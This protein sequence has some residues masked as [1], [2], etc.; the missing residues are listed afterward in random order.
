MEISL[1][2]RVIKNK[3][4]NGVSYLN[5]TDVD[6]GLIDISLPGGQDLKNDD[7]VSLEAVVE[8]GKGK[9]GLYLKVIE[10]IQI[11]KGNE[12]EPK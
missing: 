12:K 5:M 11:Q 6:G 2:G 3:T 7:L 10:V 9:Y 4:V 1:K 8:P